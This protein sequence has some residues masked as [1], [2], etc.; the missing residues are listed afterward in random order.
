MKKLT[1][2]AASLL[3]TGASLMAQQYP[4]STFEDPN[5]EDNWY[6]QYCTDTYANSDSWDGSQ[7]AKLGDDSGPS[8]FLNKTDF[9][10]LGERYRG[11][12]ICFDYYLVD[13]GD[14]NASNGINPTIYLSDG[15]NTIAFVANVTVYEGVTGWVHVCAPIEPCSSSILP[16]NADG[17]WTMGASMSCSDFNSVLY[18]SQTI[19]FPTDFTSYQ[20]EE[21]WIDNVCVRDCK[22]C[23][24]DFVL[25]PNIN[26]AT[27][28]TFADVF[29]ITT[30]PNS[31]YKVDWGDG[32]VTSPYVSHVYA[33]PGTYKVC[34]SEYDKAGKLICRTCVVFCVGDISHSEGDIKGR[35]AGPARIGDIRSMQDK[36][37][38]DEGFAIFPNPS[39]D[40]AT[41]QLPKGKNEKA[42]I[43][44]I[45]ILGKVVSETNVQANDSRAVKLNTGRLPEGIYTV[46]ITIGGKVST[47][48][49]SVAK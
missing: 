15:V 30:D 7:C 2:L 25:Q 46:E 43:R 3:F 8:W 35:A 4:C 20:T 21:M 41:L 47:Q 5:P 9:T 22:N 36:A 14:P 6:T 42:T 37:F 1:L 16:S 26:T 31:S 45:D 44:V 19:G 27:G 23:H 40:Y 11:K 13:D 28:V 29:L 24:S 18:G 10:Y 17:Q 38:N 49:I 48:K 33:G 12:C 39:K 32:A 34:V